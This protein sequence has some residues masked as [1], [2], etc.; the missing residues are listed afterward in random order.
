MGNGKP[1][2]PVNEKQFNV[3]PDQMSQRKACYYIAEASDLG[4]AVDQNKW[5]DVLIMS[6]NDG[7]KRTYSV[8]HV[9][10][11]RGVYLGILPNTGRIVVFND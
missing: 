8:T 5:P 11:K 4:F 10:E 7:A 3:E 6:M 1:N 2:F 9:N